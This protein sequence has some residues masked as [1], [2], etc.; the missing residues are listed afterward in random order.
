MN[1]GYNIFCHVF[2]DTNRFLR[3]GNRNGRIKN[4][5]ASKK[6]LNSAPKGNGYIQQ[7]WLVNKDKEQKML[8]I[9]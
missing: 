1:W 9:S 5:N 7:H 4:D 6:I 8:E 3:P 2:H